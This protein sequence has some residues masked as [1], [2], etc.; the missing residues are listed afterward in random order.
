VPQAPSP[1]RRA[2]WRGNFRAGFTLLEILLVI[3][4]FALLGAV[5][6]GGAVSL[7]KSIED[8]DPEAIVLSLL[9]KV[10]GEAVEKGQVIELTPLPDDAGFM[11]GTDGVENLPKRERLS[12]RLLRPEVSGASLIGGQLEERSIERVRF[13]PDGSCDPMRIQVVRG[14]VRRVYSID[15]WTAAP[16]PEGG[17]TP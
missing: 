13:F 17:K 9:Q 4:L 14:D 10:R 12:V 5:M 11:W 8:H 16:L 3:M 2:P 1:S 15:P 6:V 7:F